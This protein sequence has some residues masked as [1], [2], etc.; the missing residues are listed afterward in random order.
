[1][2]RFIFD[3]CA[4]LEI[5]LAKYGFPTRLAAFISKTK[6]EAIIRDA[7]FRNLLNTIRQKNPPKIAKICSWIAAHHD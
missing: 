6:R 2:D 4:E 3:I 5:D 7:K 1:M